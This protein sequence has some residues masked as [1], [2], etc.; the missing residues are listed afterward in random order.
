ME[1]IFEKRL[2]SSMNICSRKQVREALT[3]GDDISFT[4]IEQKSQ[5]MT[6]AQVCR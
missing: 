1:E 4:D 3:G 6:R 5:N 2:K